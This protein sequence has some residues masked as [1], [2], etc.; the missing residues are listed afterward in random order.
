[1]PRVPAS[2]RTRWPPS[3]RARAVVNSVANQPRPARYAANPNAATHRTHGAGRGA[4]DCADIDG[5]LTGAC[6][7]RN[8]GFRVSLRWAGNIATP[9]RAQRFRTAVARPSEGRDTAMKP[10]LTR[11]A[12]RSG[13]KAGWASLTLLPPALRRRCARGNR[14][15]CLPRAA[16]SDCGGKAFG[17]PRH[18]FR[19]WMQPRDWAVLSHSGVGGQEP[20]PRSLPIDGAAPQ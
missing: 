8:F 15:A 1:M 11:G 4:W 3:Q 10:D 9:S 5:D 14:S 17:R 7:R 20:A 18:R 2:I 6:R 19:N 12:G 16:L 13:R